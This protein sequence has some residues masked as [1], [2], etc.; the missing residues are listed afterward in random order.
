MSQDLETIRLQ[1]EIERLDREWEIEREKYRVQG[2]RGS[3]SLPTS[4]TAVMAVI[5]AI[6][7]V[8]FLLF[9]ISIAASM[10]GGI[11][12]G[13]PSGFPGGSS[14]FGSIGLCFPLFGG[15]ALILVIIGVVTNVSKASGY[16]QAEQEY[17]RKREAL[18]RSLQER[19]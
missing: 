5:G 11:S 7:A 1:N 9:W 2:S 17:L 19:R 12:F 8:L 14:P 15:V 10:F 6:V 16:S 18:I 3:S 4:G 13:E